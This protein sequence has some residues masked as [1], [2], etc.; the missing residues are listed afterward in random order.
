MTHCGAH[1]HDFVHLIQYL[2]RPEF[3]ALLSVMVEDIS[4]EAMYVRSGL[5]HSNSQLLICRNKYPLT[6]KAVHAIIEHPASIIIA[7]PTAIVVMFAEWVRGTFKQT[8]VYCCPVLP[9]LTAMIISGK[10]PYG[11]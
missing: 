3:L 6:E 1:L 8:S 2:N 9:C 7:G 11:V 5:F 10:A 4:D